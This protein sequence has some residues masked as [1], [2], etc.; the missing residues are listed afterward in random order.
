MMGLYVARWNETLGSLHM[1]G[2]GFLQSIVVAITGASG[3][4]YG[5]E[6]VN[7]LLTN[8]HKVYLV[9]SE[10]ARVVL[11]SEMNCDIKDF[12]EVASVFKPGLISW[13]DNKDIGASIASGS[14][15]HDGMVV[16]PCTMSTLAGIAHGSSNN[17]IE[18]SA[19]VCL[20]EGRPLIL[21]PRETPL[22]LIHLR[23]MVTVVEAGAKL[24]PA[25]PAFYSDSNDISDLVSFM[26]GKILDS[27]GIKNDVYRRYSPDG[28]RD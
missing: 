19:D 14:F 22:N 5:V 23:N 15:L 13:F 20:K 21:V 17:L 16:V 24:V 11:K 18:R 8:G 26:V 4:I 6:L 27:L 2:D 3:V 12:K 1:N 28:T 7:W 25:M 10:P 9:M